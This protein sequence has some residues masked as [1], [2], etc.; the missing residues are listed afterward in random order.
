MD[1]GQRIRLKEKN[2]EDNWTLKTNQFIL[3]CTKCRKYNTIPNT[4]SNNTN[5]TNNTNQKYMNCSFCGNPNY[6]KNT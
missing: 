1:K 4:N 3:K 2:A 6:I 5:N